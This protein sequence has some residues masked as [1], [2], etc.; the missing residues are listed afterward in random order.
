MGQLRKELKGCLA[1]PRMFPIRG[2]LRQRVE[3]EGPLLDFGMGKREYRAIQEKVIV[4]EEIQVNHP[5]APSF[6]RG[7][8]AQD[9]FDL[10]QA[11]EEGVGGKLR[12]QL[13]NAIEVK[14]LRRPTQGLCLMPLG[15]FDE[16]CL[17]KSSKMLKSPLKEMKPVSHVGT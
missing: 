14:A 10:L 5:R 8:S 15:N 12:F 4:R 1:K 6:V 16:A 3:N 7:R 17:G 11:L 13:G 2:D 9:C